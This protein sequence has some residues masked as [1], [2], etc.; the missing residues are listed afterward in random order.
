VQDFGDGENEVI[1]RIRAGALQAAALAQSEADF[2]ELIF[3]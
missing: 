1:D 3:E 2:V